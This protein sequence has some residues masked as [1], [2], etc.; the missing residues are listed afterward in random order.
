M[1]MFHKEASGFHALKSCLYLQHMVNLGMTLKQN[2]NT[3][4]T[5]LMSTQA[6]CVLAYL[7]QAEY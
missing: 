5:N 3:N 2:Y 1:V 7:T 4:K 6:K